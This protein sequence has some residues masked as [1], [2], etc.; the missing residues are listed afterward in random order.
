[1]IVCHIGFSGN[2]T[3]YPVSEVKRNG[4]VHHFSSDVVRDVG[5]HNYG[6]VLGHL[7]W[8][9]MAHCAESLWN[10]MGVIIEMYTIMSVQ[11][12]LAT[13]K[14]LMARFLLCR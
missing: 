2:T 5:D 10:T 11:Y 14:L 3:G 6:A 8:D 1:M 13:V 4:Q 12:C 9:R 7:N